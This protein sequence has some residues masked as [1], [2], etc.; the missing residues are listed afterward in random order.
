M[1]YVIKYTC[2]LS[3]FPEANAITVEKHV[4]ELG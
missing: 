2:W 4:V 1:L 3:S